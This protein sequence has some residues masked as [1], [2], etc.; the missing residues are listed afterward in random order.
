MRDCEREEITGLVRE[1][2]AG[3]ARAFGSLVLRF[4]PAMLVV[5]S[6]VCPSYEV[7]D[8][9]VQDAFLT[10]HRALASLHEPARF[11]PWL[12]TIVR[13]R[14]RRLAS[15]SFRVRTLP[16]HVLDEQLLR[17]TPSLTASLP[18]MAI[19]G[20]PDGVRETMQLYYIQEWGVGDIAAML[21]RPVTTVK[22]QLHAG[23]ALLRKQLGTD[24][25]TN[26]P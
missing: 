10:A 16:L 26:E 1:A 3:N 2:Q 8:D 22:W 21:D 12:A 4:R 11:G 6:Q 19:E 18:D 9:A 24:P 7:A 14:V 15:D 5:A 23:R 25:E 13:N 17:Q 20:L